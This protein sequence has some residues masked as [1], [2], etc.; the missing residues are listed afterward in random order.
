MD[1]PNIIVMLMDNLGYGNLQCC[2]CTHHRTPHIDRLTSEGIWFTADGREQFFRLTDDPTECHNLA[3]KPG[4]ADRIAYWRNLLIKELKDRPE[5]FTD[6]KKLFP[7]RPYP[8]VL[9]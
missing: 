2:G 4:E 1:K 9:K 3:G 5:G 7:G 8:A 6:G